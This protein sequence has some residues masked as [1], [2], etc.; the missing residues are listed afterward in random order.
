MTLARSKSS[1]APPIS[2]V[3]RLTYLATDSDSG[4]IFGRI[5]TPWNW[6]IKGFVG[7]GKIRDG[8]MNDFGITGGPGDTLFV[9]YSNTISSKVDGSIKYA[10]VDIDYNW[11]RGPTYKVGLFVGYN[12]YQQHMAAHGCAQIADPNS[13]CA[14][15]EPVSAVPIITQDTKWKSLRI[16]AAGEFMPLERIK[17]SGEVAY[18]PYVKLN[19]LDRHLSTLEILRA[20]TQIGDTAEAFSSKGSTATIA[21]TWSIPVIGW[22]KPC[23]KPLASPCPGASATIGAKRKLKSAPLGLHVSCC[24]PYRRWLRPRLAWCWRIRRFV[25]QNGHIL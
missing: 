25:P 7:R 6:F 23:M 21:K 24:P 20:S 2:A 18:L 14:I 19:G 11:W 5:D 12:R 9:P 8:H 1:G 10:T 4:E 15:P 3:S 22:A 17:L 16:G 13:V